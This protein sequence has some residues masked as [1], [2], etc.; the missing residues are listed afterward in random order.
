[1]LKKKLHVIERELDKISLNKRLEIEAEH[2]KRIK[3]NR[4]LRIYIKPDQNSITIYTRILGEFKADDTM[5]VW[6]LVKRFMV[7]ANT[8][9][10]QTVYESEESEDNSIDKTVSS[11]KNNNEISSSNGNESCF[12]EIR[13]KKDNNGSISNKDNNYNGLLSSLNNF[14]EKNNFS[15]ENNFLQEN[16]ILGE[17]NISGDSEN[18]NEI[19][20]YE[21]TVESGAHAFLV[22]R[23]ESCENYQIMIKM[24]NPMNVK[25]LKPKLATLFNRKTDTLQNLIKEFYRYINTNKLYDYNTSIVKCNDELRKIFEMDSLAFKDIAY[26]LNYMLESIDYCVINVDLN[27][28]EIWDIHA[29]C[30]DLNQMPILYPKIVQEIENKIELNKTAQKNTNEKIQTLEEFIKDPL[31]FINRKISID[32][33]SRGLQTGFYDDLN[34]QTAIFELIKR[35][36]K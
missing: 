21:W 20:V 13:F 11:D 6:D 8:Y 29:E 22:K 9:M 1:M 15:P 7:T 31:F 4:T 16:K 10:K 32:S 28:E 30:D 23:K 19:E 18:K 25:K 5:N 35:H 3:K 14:T 34:V 17:N 26:Y 12:S 33:D 24:L 27:K 36:E 2:M